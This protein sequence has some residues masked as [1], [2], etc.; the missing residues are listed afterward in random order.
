MKKI[1]LVAFYSKENSNIEINY[2]INDKELLA[3]VDW[4]KK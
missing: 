3:I 4:F 1:Q 2:K